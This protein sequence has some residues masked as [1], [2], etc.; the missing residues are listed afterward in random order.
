MKLPMKCAL[1]SAIPVLVACQ[2]A[3]RAGAPSDQLA[4]HQ[5]AE[6][7]TTASGINNTT[8]PGRGNLGP[9][10]VNTE[11]DDFEVEVKSR[12]NLDMVFVNAV[13]FPGGQSGWHYHPGPAFLVVKTGALTVYTADDATCTGK[14]FPAGTVLIEGTTPHIV[15]NEG[16]V[17]AEFSVVFMVPAGTAQRRDA[18][19]PGNCA[20]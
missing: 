8:L 6:V 16:T 4:R 1:Y 15:R 2:D 7:S 14:V 12:Q 18:P 19:A 9:V 5:G 13:A 11:F 17:N 20:F 10:G 3:G